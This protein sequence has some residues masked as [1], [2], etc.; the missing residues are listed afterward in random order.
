VA[1]GVGAVGFDLALHGLL[2]GEK[3]RH[4]DA[5]LAVRVGVARGLAVGFGL[6]LVS[7]RSGFFL[8]SLL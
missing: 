8:V 4:G 2:P 1:R 7:I 3:R 5:R 6:G